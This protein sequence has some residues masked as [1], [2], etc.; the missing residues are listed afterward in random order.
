MGL[1]F[2]VCFAAGGSFVVFVC[3]FLNL[4][5]GDIIGLC[6][7]T[8]K[9]TCWINYLYSFLPPTHPHFTLGNHFNM[10]SSESFC[11]GVFLAKHIIVCAF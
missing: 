9:L 7:L 4:H 6:D 5:F 2:F 8:Q 11:L 10:L 3:L 1:G